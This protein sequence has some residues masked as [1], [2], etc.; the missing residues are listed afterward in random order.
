MKNI[1]EE[2]GLTYGIYSSLNPFKNDCMFSIGA[3]V[4]KEKKELA[5]SEIKLE[6]QKLSTEN[7]SQEELSTAKNHLFGSLQL[8]IANPF[9][10]LDKIKNIRLND[11]G[12]NFYRNLFSSIHLANPE[13]IQLTAEKYLS[14]KDMFEVSVG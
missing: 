4:G 7:I 14:T 1:R 9:A 10:A 5:L 3:D 6:L 8:E 2:K 13:S 12:E 11:L